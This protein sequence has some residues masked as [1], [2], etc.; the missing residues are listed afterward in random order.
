MQQSPN[1]SGKLN[2]HAA[3]AIQALTL[4]AAILAANAVD[5]A[6]K[7]KKP[8]AAPVAV[9]NT[10]ATGTIRGKVLDS[11]NGEPMIG[12][13]AVIKDLGL[14]GI[15]DIDGNYTITNVPVGQQR[16]TYQI[17]GYQPASTAVAVAQGKPARA[18]VTMNYKVSGEVVVTAKRMDSTAASLLSKQKKAAAA[19][20]AISAEQISKSP[21]SD[22]SD[23]AR[24]V[25]GITIV[26][27]KYVFVRGLGER[28]SSVQFNGSGIVSPEPEKRVV[29]LDIFPASMLDNIIV[30]KTY[31]PDLPGE[32][33]GG[34][35]QLNSRDFPEE[36]ELKVSISTGFHSLTTFKDFRT[37]SGGNMDFIGVDDGTRNIPALV[38]NST[39]NR[40]LTDATILYPQGFSA[41]QLEKFG[42]SFSN[43]W[44]ANTTKGNLPGGMAV[45]YAKGFKNAAGKNIFGVQT[46]GMFKESSR[47]QERIIKTYNVQG[48][49]QLDYVQRTST[50]STTKGALLGLAWLPATHD[51]FRLN[52]FYTHN[53]EKE[54]REVTGSNQDLGANVIDT[55]LAYGENGLL[56]NQLTGEHALPNFLEST[57]SWKAAYSR[58][59]RI[60]PDQ[61]NTIYTVQPN[62][63]KSLTIRD[64]S[65]LRFYNRNLEQVIDLNPELSI[66]FNQ[67]SGLKSKFTNG[68]ALLLKER[69]A[70]ARRFVFL[71]PTGGVSAAELGQSPNQLFTPQNIA[72]DKFVI[73]EI[74]QPA[75]QFTGQ[76]LIAAGYSMVDLPLIPQVRLVAGARYEFSDFRVITKDIYNPA[77]TNTA[78]IKT[79]NVMPSAN[80]IYS[81]ISDINIRVAYSQTVARPDFRELSPFTY[82]GMAGGDI[83]VGN[84]L[85][86]QT[87]IK[88]YDLRFEWFPSPGEII[89][90]SGFYK[91]L[92]KPVEMTERFSS[93]LLVS[94]TNVP[95]AY[96]AG[97]E[98]ELRKNFG[99]IAKMIEDF[100]VSSNLAYIVSKVSLPEGGIYT[101]R[102]R[103][104]QG[105]SPFVVNAG[106]NYDNQK[107]GTSAAVLYNIFGRRMVRVGS[108][109]LGDTYEEPFGKMDLMFRQRVTEKGSI[110][111]TAA[112][113]LNP[114]IEAKQ[115]DRLRFQY[116]AGIDVG[117][118]FDYK[119]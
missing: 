8:A 67:W 15:T 96:I 35:V 97:G 11:A 26:G 17:T 82:V 38:E 27:G 118:S 75:D 56:F 111:L 25:T 95:N 33:G 24:R 101:N 103:P 12:V 87:E 84:P 64:E 89:S 99:F 10:G 85:L 20:D 29:P 44:E 109:G 48:D 110:K 16:V 21:D 86:T 69:E 91:D 78:Q 100:S 90:L 94:Y 106:L 5:A 71:N 39:G 113:I 46:S 88:N 114:L 108:L 92:V 19:Q 59:T 2:R 58:A 52:T 23:A 45:S 31:T 63:S 98:L 3:K 117:I 13:T 51:K 32:F 80:L 112:N 4:F 119:I 43:N 42:E 6:P 41:A 104:L 55:R 81:P 79:Q 40:R 73:K 53:S 28:Y 18:N 116:R 49:T 7:G 93:G 70:V 9:A 54:V 105:Q 66:P 61:R 36:D 22:A 65:P 57:V 60:E 107:S 83:F 30:V 115:N 72:A 47:N 50:Y 14:Y 34:V 74:T 102:E 77:N 62:G 76:H 37:Y 1:I 68:A